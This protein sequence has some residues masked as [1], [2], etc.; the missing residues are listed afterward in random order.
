M[1]LVLLKQ[2]RIRE[3]QIGEGGVCRQSI[4]VETAFKSSTVIHVH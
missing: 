3:D 4:F 2:V 1:F